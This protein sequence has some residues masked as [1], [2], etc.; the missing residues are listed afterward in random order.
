MSSS[1]KGEFE[2]VCHRN[3]RDCRMECIESD[4]SVETKRF[5]KAN[6]TKAKSYSMDYWPP[7]HAYGYNF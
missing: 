5:R 3:I 2:D 4:I 6:Y 7:Y 1:D